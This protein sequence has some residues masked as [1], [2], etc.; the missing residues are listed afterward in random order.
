[1][2]NGN[3]DLDMGEL[4]GS[5]KRIWTNSKKTTVRLDKIDRTE[6][7]IFKE[8][9]ELADLVLELNATKQK[10]IK[11]IDNKLAEHRAKIAVVEAEKG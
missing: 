5:A 6:S 10:I 11:H 2:E 8:D 9:N 4:I 3:E 7:I 1:M